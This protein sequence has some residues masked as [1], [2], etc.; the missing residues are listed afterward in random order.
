[1]EMETPTREIEILKFTPSGRRTPSGVKSRK[2]GQDVG[3]NPRARAVPNP[4]AKGKECRHCGKL[5]HFVDGCFSKTD[6]KGKPLLANEKDANNMEEAQDVTVPCGNIS[7]PL[8]HRARTR[9]QGP[10]PV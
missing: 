4:R 5:N 8:Q 9:D 3:K 1:M 7:L 2:S 6:S 10:K